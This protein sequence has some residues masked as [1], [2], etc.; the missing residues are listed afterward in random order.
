M[1][2]IRHGAAAA[3]AVWIMSSGLAPAH[4]A[5]Q[6]NDVEIGCTGELSVS[7]VD[8]LVMTCSADLSLRGLSVEAGIFAA[9]SIFISSTG[10]LSLSDLRLNSPQVTI[11]SDTAVW[12][13]DSVTLGGGLP[14]GLSPVVRISAG[15]TRL[16][17][18]PNLS[19]ASGVISIGGSGD[20]RPGVELIESVG[21]NVRLTTGGTLQVSNVPEPSTWALL[22]TGL[23]AISLRARRRQ[24]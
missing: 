14:E 13:V 5:F 17:N 9:E 18:D 15:E 7:G 10:R 21:G 24:A 11:T 1:K 16:S 8:A 3:L 23:L 12:L 20:L 2:S 22:F 4:A 6:V 19:G